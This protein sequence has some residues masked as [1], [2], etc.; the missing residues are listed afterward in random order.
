MKYNSNPD[1]SLIEQ[2]GIH[3]GGVRHLAEGDP[4]VD[5]RARARALKSEF[6]IGE[7]DIEFIKNFTE[8]GG[9][10]DEEIK[11][12]KLWRKIQNTQQVVST[13]SSEMSN[14]IAALHGDNR[15]MN[16]ADA[17]EK[18]GEKRP[19][20]QSTDDFNTGLFRGNTK[21]RKQIRY[22][23]IRN[24]LRAL[25][26]PEG[27]IECALITY[28][29]SLLVELTRISSSMIHSLFLS[30]LSSYRL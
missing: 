29:V 22:N 1:G 28:V 2:G 23:T 19:V 10:Q 3:G 7:F 14:L 26:T 30:S 24:I 25:V 8:R 12:K 27:I 9:A 5:A 4:D 15:K 13:V 20:R 17:Q 21:N 11:V 16:Q 18:S 6:D